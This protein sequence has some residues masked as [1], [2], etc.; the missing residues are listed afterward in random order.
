MAL[1][2][3]QVCVAGTQTDEAALGTALELGKQFNGHVEAVHGK[4][5]PRESLIVIGPGVGGTM[6]QDMLR[7]AEEEVAARV[8]AV[9]RVFDSATADLGGNGEGQNGFG[10]SLT[11][12]EGRHATI[13]AQRGQLA[14]LVVAARQTDRNDVDE[15]ETL[16]TVLFES[17]RPVLVVPPGHGQHG[18]GA[19]AIAWDG[20]LEASRA[21]HG[22][23]PLLEAAERVV[24]L[25]V[26]EAGKAPASSTA[27]A[28]A[29]A[30]H[31]VAATPQ[32]VKGEGAI[33]V[34]L[35]GA[36]ADAGCGLLVMGGYGHSRLREL[37][38][39]GVTRDVLAASALPVLLAH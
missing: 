10:A 36:A 21:V 4:A 16:E 23:M 38:L 19:V 1:K 28:A 31:D 15:I 14:D 3:I 35:L 32:T 24:I 13:V 2:F 5:D 22:A 29:L 18:F 17:G 37:V 25:M 27:L 8:S 11:I 39:G 30:W 34:A 33:S 26:E 6:V 20:S 12:V 7:A 9:Q